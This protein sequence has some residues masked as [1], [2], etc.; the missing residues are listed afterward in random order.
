MGIKGLHKT[1]AGFTGQAFRL[2]ANA[3]FEMALLGLLLLTAAAILCQGQL[4][5]RTIRFTPVT[6]ASSS[7][8]VF[9]DGDTDGK[10]SVRDD[11][12]LH[13]NCELRAGNAYPY[14]G[15]EL[16]LDK[17]RGIHGIDLSNMRSLAITM[18]YRGASTSFRVHLK[19]FDPRYS[20]RAD[21]ES[22]K[23]LRVEADTTP[24]KLQRTEFV[25]SDFG[26]ADW[27]LRKRKLPPEFGRPQ[28]DNVTS[29]IIETGSEAPLGHHAFDIRSIEVRKAILSDAQWY[30]LLLGIWIVMIV[31]YL[32]YR[33]GNLRRALRERQTLEALA[34]SDAQEAARRDHLTGLLN[35]RGLTERFADLVQPRRDAVPLAVILIDIDH[36]K[37]LNDA[38]GHD[39]GD[40][41]LASFATVINWNIRAAD[42]AAR[43]GGEE[44]VV[45]CAD[46]DRRGAQKIA[47]KLRECVEGFDFGICG[48]VTASFGIHWSRELE[49]ELPPMVAMA[50]AALYAA[51]AGGRNCCRLHKADMSKVA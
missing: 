21:D 28:F 17:N 5:E 23:Y 35:R 15:Y 29:L 10:S 30:S 8:L 22:P 11:S 43:W 7:H 12:P 40:Q 24:G 44:F 14:C 38:F 42:M 45:V 46:V 50:D 51:K 33:V 1:I 34:L 20:V 49:P 2:A 31:L 47:E 6:T 16:F 48:Q 26:V 41:V 3:K 37:A 4:L 18:M 27:W 39:Y 32:G 25:P 13:W 36:F 19:N 9:S